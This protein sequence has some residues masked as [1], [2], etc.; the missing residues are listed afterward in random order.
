MTQIIMNAP[1]IMHE[2]NFTTTTLRMKSWTLFCR[3]QGR[4]PQQKSW[5][6]AILPHLRN[7]V[8]YIAYGLT[9]EQQK[10]RTMMALGLVALAKALAPYGI[11]SSDGEITV[12]LIREF[13]TSDEEMKIAL[14]VVKQRAATVLRRVSQRS[15]SNNNSSRLFESFW[16][17]LSP[18]DHCGTCPKIRHFGDHWKEVNE[19]K[20]EADP[21]RKMVMETIT[22]VIATLGA[23]DI[24][25]R[26][27][28]RLVDGIIYPFQEQTGVS[29]WTVSVPS[30]ILSASVPSLRQQAVDLTTRLGPAVVIKQCEE[31]QL[32]S[33][34]GLILFEQLG[35]ESFSRI[36]ATEGVIANIVADRGAEFVPAREWMHICFEI[37][38][39]LKAHKKGV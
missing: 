17:Q 23:S 25:E 38:D 28:V 24:D 6:I 35:E 22:E 5:Q 2:D 11:E 7:L 21:Y 9:D 4:L 3:P 19:V 12:I 27:E 1:R 13:Q 36:I 37:L 14:K 30:S 29:S 34:L 26:L 8:A 10:V 20:D 32:L 39:L 16:T 15:T 33:K 18:S 31:D